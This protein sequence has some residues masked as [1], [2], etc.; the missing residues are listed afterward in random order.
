MV[1]DKF[2]SCPEYGW[3]KLGIKDV[4]KSEKEKEKQA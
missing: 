3:H 1:N 2:L 4:R